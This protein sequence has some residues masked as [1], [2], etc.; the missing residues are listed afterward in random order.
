MNLY[1]ALILISLIIWVILVLL[2]L[3]IFILVIFIIEVI[4]GVSC[5]CLYVKGKVMKVVCRK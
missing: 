3:I 2:G 1:D 4:G 5:W